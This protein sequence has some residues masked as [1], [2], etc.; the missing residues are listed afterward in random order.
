[1]LNIMA[2]INIGFFIG[3][4]SPFLPL[5]GYY[6]LATIFNL[7]NLRKNSFSGILKVLF[8]KKTNFRFKL[9]YLIYFLVSF[10]FMAA[11]VV[12]QIKFL[13]FWFSSQLE[14]HGSL[15]EVIMN[16]K[17]LL[18]ILIIIIARF[19]LFIIKKTYKLYK[20]KRMECL[21][22]ILSISISH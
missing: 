9:I 19:T 7:P 2:M 12:Y 16:S 18:G 22:C 1:M 20:N 6:L 8:K 5:D 4:L 3:N 13:Y 11:I 17:V 10:S 21:D 14:K 15:N